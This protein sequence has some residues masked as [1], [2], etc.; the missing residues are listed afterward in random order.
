MKRDSEAFFYPEKSPA[1]CADCGL[2]ET[3]CPMK[4]A[5][6]DIRKCA[7]PEAFAL[8]HKDKQILRSS[9]S[10]GAF[11]AIA[12]AFCDAGSA[13]FGAS[14]SEDYHNVAHTCVTDLNNLSAHRKSK[15]IQSDIGDSYRQARDLLSSGKKT[16][17][18]GTPCQIAGLKSLL[19]GKDSP[20]LLTVDL[21]CHGVPS[22][23]VYAKYLEYL[24]S[25]YGGSVVS[26]DFKN[27][28]KFG[29]GTNVKVGLAKKKALHT[30]GADDPFIIAFLSGLCLRPSCHACPF[31]TT[32]RIS[33][34]TIGDLWGAEEIVPHLDSDT[35]LSVLLAN[36]EKAKKLLPD[37]QRFSHIE[38]IDLLKVAEH[39]SNLREPSPPN[40]KRGQFMADVNKEPFRDV[41]RAYLKP[42]PAIHR[43][44]ARVLSK[45][46]KKRL[47][48]IL[49]R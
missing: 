36:T 31:A 12:Q 17:F 11:T 9:S 4:R 24:K 29:C 19:M 23:L 25:M 39:N 40:P 44:A 34:F 45:K 20:N 38:A 16:L 2:C 30:M 37:I 28:E 10:G 26:V 13:I 42:R 21:I 3:A 49:R 1:G 47:K 32:P 14:F 35:G 41:V 46:A 27:K 18:S 33:D 43:L 7:A 8:Y 6:E 48:A 22:Q 5:V 15:Y